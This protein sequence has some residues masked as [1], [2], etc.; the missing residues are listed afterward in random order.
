M[1]RDLAGISVHAYRFPDFFR[2]DR[3]E[4]VKTLL[5]QVNDMYFRGSIYEPLAIS[6]THDFEE[7][8][9]LNIRAREAL[10]R[11]AECF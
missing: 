7:S 6:R 9:F 3:I 5:S 8:V 1:H 10:P 2:H 4:R 11:S